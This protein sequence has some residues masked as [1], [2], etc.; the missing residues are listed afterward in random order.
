M[1]LSLLSF[2]TSLHVLS[3]RCMTLRKLLMSSGPV[4]VGPLQRALQWQYELLRNSPFAPPPD[5][6]ASNRTAREGQA[7]TNGVKEQKAAPQTVSASAEGK[8]PSLSSFD[9]GF[10]GAGG[11]QLDAW[12]GR[13][14]V[15]SLCTSAGIRDSVSPPQIH[16]ENISSVSH[17]EDLREPFGSSGN[18]SRASI[19]II[20][21]VTVDSLNLEIKVKRSAALPSNPWLSLPVDNLENSYTV[22]ITQNP[23]PHKGDL[24]FRCRDQ[25]TQT[26]ALSRTQPTDWALHS[27]S[28]LED[29][30]LSPIRKVLSSTI[31]TEVRERSILTTE[32]GAT[33]LWDSYDLHEQVQ[34]AV[35]G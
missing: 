16:E 32:G 23:T 20:P 26:D 10:D 25:P 28:S 17:P 31:I 8:P 1:Y 7:L 12:G 34:D 14:G 15:E 27:R 22:T 19:L 3:I 29:P 4:A 13:E 9:S 30:E 24:Q 21:K 5:D 6:G 33:L 18:S 35:D 11:C 2:T